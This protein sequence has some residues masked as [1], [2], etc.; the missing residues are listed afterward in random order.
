MHRDADGMDTDVQ[1][2]KAAWGRNTAAWWGC[3][4]S[5]AAGFPQAWASGRHLGCPGQLSVLG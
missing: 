5:R 1:R 4:W 3:G 2:G